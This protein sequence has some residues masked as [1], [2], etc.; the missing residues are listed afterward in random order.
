MNRTK[1]LLFTTF[2]FSWNNFM[3]PVEKKCLGE[4]NALIVAKMESELLNLEGVK[5][6]NVYDF[7]TLIFGLMPKLFDIEVEMANGHKYIFE[8]IPEDLRFWIEASR[9]RSIDSQKFRTTI[10]PFGIS[11]DSVIATFFGP[12]YSFF[13]DTY[14]GIVLSK[15]SGIENLKIRTLPDFLKN[16]E[17]FYVFFTKPE[18][19]I[20][21]KKNLFRKTTF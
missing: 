21:Y 9:I 17:T 1:F 8:C 5:E 6:A 2:V 4:E 10:L 13:L 19:E 7:D 18:K 12:I 20:R 14:P 3:F 15:I 16:E 11:T